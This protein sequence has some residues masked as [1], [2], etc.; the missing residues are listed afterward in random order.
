MPNEDQNSVP[1]PAAYNTSGL[2]GDDDAASVISLLS[3][4]PRLNLYQ[5]ELQ[6]IAKRDKKGSD[7]GPFFETQPPRNVNIEMLKTLLKSPY[8]WL[9]ESDGNENLKLVKPSTSAVLRDRVVSTGYRC[10][11][12]V[13]GDA[14]GFWSTHGVKGFDGG[15]LPWKVK[16]QE[17]K[18]S[19]I[20]SALNTPGFW[21]CDVFCQDQNSSIPE[22]F[23]IMGHI[24]SCC[25]ETLALI[26]VRSEAIQMFNANMSSLTPMLRY[27]ALRTRED[28]SE[29]VVGTHTQEIPLVKR[30]TG[31]AASL[32]SDSDWKVLLRTAAY[33]HG[34]KEDFTYGL[35][36]ILDSSWFKRVWTLQEAVLPRKVIL[37]SERLSLGSNGVRSPELE[38]DLTLIIKIAQ[39]LHLWTFPVIYS[40]DYEKATE[41]KMNEESN[42]Y[43]SGYID[44]LSR[45]TS[46][47][48]QIQRIALEIAL[49][50]KMQV[51][52]KD[53]VLSANIRE[54]TLRSLAASTRTCT[55]HQDYFY[56]V[57]GLLEID[58]ELGLNPEGALKSFLTSLRELGIPIVSPFVGSSEKKSDSW[59]GVENWDSMAG[60]FNRWRQ[61]STTI[62]MLGFDMKFSENGDV[63]IAGEGVTMTPTSKIRILKE[64]R[65]DADPQVLRHC[66]A[67]L[68][69]NEFNGEP[70]SSS[71]N[72]YSVV[73]HSSSKPYPT[74]EPS[75]I[76]SV[77]SR[78][79]EKVVRNRL[80]LSVEAMFVRYS[81][82]IL[83][84]IDPI[85][86]K[87]VTLE[88]CLEDA[89]GT[90][91]SFEIE[92]K[93]F[94][95]MLL[96]YLHRIYVQY[97]VFGDELPFDIKEGMEIVHLTKANGSGLL[98]CSDPFEYKL[99]KPLDFILGTEKA[100]NQSRAKLYSHK[101]A[102]T[103]MG[104][105]DEYF[106]FGTKSL[107][108]CVTAIKVD[109]QCKLL[110]S[111]LTSTFGN[112]SAIEDAKVNPEFVNDHFLNSIGE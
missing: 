7:E 50:S 10:I 78:L 61:V 74:I 22:Q 103:Y 81:M 26:N 86:G 52:L 4:D 82:D 49:I 36:A 80:D 66:R 19:R 33:R 104:R 23:Q 108:L 48:K 90:H 88:V 51:L 54:V 41:T 84:S 42:A 71:V 32:A 79:P 92:A 47:L 31:I 72:A 16:M 77:T 8:F 94:P 38:I 15:A 83:S 65:R 53:R 99:Y 101:M 3:N 43:G 24:Y 34:A 67:M 96:Y 75:L 98:V 21:W 73:N 28:L 93:L 46:H 68:T 11:S 1:A 89:N 112:T 14:R 107:K 58:V 69:H 37:M 13:W 110:G 55:Q 57:M 30:L 25:E 20:L 39:A 106:G 45:L 62:E 17:G 18:R 97:D 70:S 85:D 59:V 9:V 56:G 40:V 5:D 100:A 95:R 111:L 27:L 87:M 35:T 6:A 12:H 91:D 109:N 102:Q 44:L 64:H 105:D 76:P 60:V 29:S 2:N 63:S